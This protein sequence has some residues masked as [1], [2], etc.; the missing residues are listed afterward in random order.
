MW[1]VFA[2]SKNRLEKG[3]ETCHFRT[4]EI[5]R[6][7]FE[8]SDN[9]TLPSVRKYSCIQNIESTLY[10]TLYKF[11]DTQVCIDRAEDHGCTLQ[12]TMDIQVF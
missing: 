9:M 6:K 8:F 10:Y 1:E 5:K 2:V 3:C 7:D 12:I 4:M 11:D